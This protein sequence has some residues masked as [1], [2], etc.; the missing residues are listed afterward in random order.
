M[1]A[2]FACRRVYQKLIN[3]NELKPTPSHPINSIIK[4]PAETKNI[5]NPAKIV[6]KKKNID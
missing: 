1:A 3:K 2:L 6:N 5:I 4:L